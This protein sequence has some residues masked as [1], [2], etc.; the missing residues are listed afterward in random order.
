M[1]SLH[2]RSPSWMPF[3]R[4][5]SIERQENTSNSDVTG[6]DALPDVFDV[7]LD[8][9]PSVGQA[10]PIQVNAETGPSALTPNPMTTTTDAGTGERD[11]GTTSDGAVFQPPPT[12]DVTQEA[13]DALKKILK[14][15]RDTGGG[16]KASG[17][18]DVLRERLQEMKQFLWVYVDPQSKS[19]G[20]WM[21]SSTDT[22]RALEKKP[23]H[24]RV[25]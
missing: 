4:N 16:Y 9:G 12:I 18:D 8:N 3:T 11:N 24:V 15:P 21:M 22:A 10:E 1:P 13:L 6:P 20:K 19:H 7:S 5:R 14:P 2:I 23:W 17:L 25:I